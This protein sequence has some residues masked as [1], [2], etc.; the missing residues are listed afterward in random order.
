[1]TCEDDPQKKLVHLFFFI[2]GA[3]S[4][5]VKFMKCAMMAVFFDCTKHAESQVQL[6]AKNERKKAFGLQLRSLIV[7]S[8]FLAIF[9]WIH[10]SIMRFTSFKYLSVVIGSKFSCICYLNTANSLT[11][12]IDGQ[13]REKKEKGSMDRWWW[14]TRCHVMASDGFGEKIFHSNFTVKF[15]IHCSWILHTFVSFHSLM[16]RMTLKHSSVREFFNFVDQNEIFC[17]LRCF[18]DFWKNQNLNYFNLFDFK[19]IE[20]FVLVSVQSTNL[21]QLNQGKNEIQKLSI[22]KKFQSK[23]NRQKS[24]VYRTVFNFFFWRT[25]LTSKIPLLR[26][27]ALFLSNQIMREASNCF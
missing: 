21:C 13:K 6:E 26:L 27:H 11:S 2:P 23:I 4:L 22:K 9:C 14:S 20:N 15:F 17:C 25:T 12:P 5:G 24:K 16:T 3:V 18:N 8:H 19:I 10:S 7:G 1:M